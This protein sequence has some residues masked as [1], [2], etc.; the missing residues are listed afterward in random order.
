VT[1]LREWIEK[2]EFA[3]AEEPVLKTHTRIFL[4]SLYLKEKLL[5]TQAARGH[6]NIQNRNHRKCDA[7][8]GQEDRHRHRS[9]K[10]PRTSL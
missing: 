6:W 1:V 10:Q 3:D 8:A 4:S 7:F 9:P 2:K 5:S